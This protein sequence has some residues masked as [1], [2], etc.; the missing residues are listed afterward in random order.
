MATGKPLTESQYKVAKRMLNHNHSITYLSGV[1]EL[2][3]PTLER[4]KRTGTFEHYRAI[5]RMQHGKASDGSKLQPVRKKS[6]VARL[7]GR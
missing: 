3:V 2:S 1:C 6:F 7:F 5:S 4:I